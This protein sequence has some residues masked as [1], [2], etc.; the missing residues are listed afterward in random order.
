MESS[1][2]ENNRAK[3]VRPGQGLSAVLNERMGSYLEAIAAGLNG[4]FVRLERLRPR[5]RLVHPAQQF[6]V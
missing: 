5:E 2:T 3:R 6:I 4:S 1:P